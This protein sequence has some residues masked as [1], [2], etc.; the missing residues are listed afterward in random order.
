[1]FR[2][3]AIQVRLAKA[4]KPSVPAEPKT[5]TLDLSQ[6][7]SDEARRAFVV[8][9]GAYASVKLLN[10]ACKVAIIAASK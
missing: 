6:I 9:F 2:D 8:L 10:T 3:R 5:V 7:T 1:M 4:D